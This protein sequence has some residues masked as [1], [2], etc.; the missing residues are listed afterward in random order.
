MFNRNE[1]TQTDWLELAK[2]YGSDS[3]KKQERAEESFARCDTDGFLSQWASEQ[4][5]SLDSAKRSLCENFGKWNF[6]GLFDGT[7][8]V[9][10]KEIVVDDYYTGNK[11]TVWLLH[12]DER[13]KFGNRKFLPYNHGNGKSRILNGF[14]LQELEVES[15][16]WV[17]HKSWGG[18]HID[19]YFFRVENEWGENDVLCEVSD[20]S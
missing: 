1:M 13:T 20:D 15:P 16:A 6:F 10:A 7:R 11:K 19:T 5:S 12:E 2:Q 17:T 3:I 8:R 14:N 18:M 9:K 4:T